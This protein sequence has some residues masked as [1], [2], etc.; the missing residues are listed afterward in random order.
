[1]FRALGSL[2][3]FQEAPV[4]GQP[5]NMISPQWCKKWAMFESPNQGLCLIIQVCRVTISE[6]LV[7]GGLK[8]LS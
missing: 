3:I 5:T 1:M 2:Q 6:A 8:R 4:G 7:F